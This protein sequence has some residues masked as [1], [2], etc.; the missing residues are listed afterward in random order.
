MTWSLGG[1]ELESLGFMFFG[2]LRLSP[3]CSQRLNS[4]PR[5]F[6]SLLIRNGS[7]GEIV[8]GI[9]L[10]IT[11]EN[12][13]ANL[14]LILIW[15]HIP[16]QVLPLPEPS[17]PGP[18]D[19]PPRRR[20]RAVGGL[21]CQEPSRQPRERPGRTL[22]DTPRPPPPASHQDFLAQHMSGGYPWKS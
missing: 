17:A 11:L 1:E 21:P 3:I 22:R 18:P 7:Q 20:R 14:R 13:V 4:P 19:P 2:V 8:D 10:E 15:E 6:F 12:L 9:G 16:P 5:E